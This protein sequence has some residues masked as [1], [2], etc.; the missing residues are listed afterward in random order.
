MEDRTGKALIYTL[1]ALR[2]EHRGTRPYFDR[3]ESCKAADALAKKAEELLE[4]DAFPVDPYFVG[5]AEPSMSRFSS[6]WGPT[7][8]RVP[9]GEQERA[10]EPIEKAPGFEEEEEPPPAT[11]IEE[12]PPKRGWRRVLQR[13]F[14]EEEE[15]GD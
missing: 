14:L 9:A 3:E 1:L 11:M 12:P 4:D 2:L 13:L 10:P 7:A 8:D 5:W 6:L 15:K